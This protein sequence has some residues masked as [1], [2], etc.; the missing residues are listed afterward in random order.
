MYPYLS[1]QNQNF[2]FALPNK[3]FD[4]RAA[5]AACASGNCY[6]DHDWLVLTIFD[7]RGKNRSY[8]EVTQLQKLLRV[9]SVLSILPTASP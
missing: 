2:V 1:A 5:N 8:W 7:E 9:G 4:D 6:S 3:F